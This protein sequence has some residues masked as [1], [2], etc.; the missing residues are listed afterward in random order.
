MIRNMHGMTLTV[1]GGSGYIHTGQ[2]HKLAE[3]S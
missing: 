1:G 2:R 3:S